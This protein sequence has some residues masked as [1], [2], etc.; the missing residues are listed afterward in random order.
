ML[1]EVPMRVLMLLSL[2]PVLNAQDGA[3]WNDLRSKNPPGLSVTL[4]LVNPHAFRQ[5]ELI[6]AELNLPPVG[7]PPPTEQ[8]QF[9]GILLDPATVCGSVAKPC[10]LNDASA[11]GIRI[12]NGAQGHSD[13]QPL[14][15]NSYLPPLTRGRYHAAA[16]ARKLVL[17]N[18]GPAST[19]YLYANPPQYAVSE[20]VEIEI[21]AATADWIRQTVAR[22]V[23]TLHGPQPRDTTGNQARQDA[24]QQLAFLNDPAAWTASLDLLPEQEY[25]LL[26]GLARGRPPSRI[27][28]LMQARVSAP[29]QSVSSAYL[30]RLT[31][32]CAQANL[33]PAPPMPASGAFRPMVAVGVIS[34]TPPPVATP[35]APPNP[36]MQAWV[37]KRH[38]Y[39][40]DRWAMPRPR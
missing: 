22:S 28:E 10:F 27:C 26:A 36:E 35:L 12:M 4:R 11:G 16:L 37:E 20:A 33:T 18:R 24:A 19:S 29:T 1:K 7:S 14:A 30:Y 23:A 34:T 8:W 5:G 39:T 31:E 32:I 9:A 21:I 25:M 38:A 2:A 13:H 40:E 3:P 15:L 17:G 6:A